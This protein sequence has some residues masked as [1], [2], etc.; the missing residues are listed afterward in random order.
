[1]CLMQVLWNPFM[2]ILYV[3]NVLL[4]SFCFC[5][6]G[7]VTRLAGG[8][9]AGGVSAGSVDGTGSAATFYNPVGIAVSSSGAVYVADIGNN[10]IRMISPTG[11]LFLSGNIDPLC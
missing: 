4:V 8:G 3:I 6:E 9:S 5:P 10:L 7:M 11:L 1:M 2:L